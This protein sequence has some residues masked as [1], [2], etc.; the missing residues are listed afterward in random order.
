MTASLV[1]A[2]I[3]PKRIKVTEKYQYTVEPLKSPVARPIPSA[4]GKPSGEWEVIIPYDGGSNFTEAHWRAIQRQWS[5]P[6]WYAL[7]QGLRGFVNF[8][9]RRRT[10]AATDSVLER[11]VRIG[12][13]AF[14]DYHRTDLRTRLQLGIEHDTIQLDLPVQ[15]ADLPPRAI[16]R[17]QHHC[18]IHDSYEPAYPD[19]SPVQLKLKVQDEHELPASLEAL[20]QR[21]APTTEPGQVFQLRLELSEAQMFHQPNHFIPGLHVWLHLTVNFPEAPPEPPQLTQLAL[22]WPK[23]LAKQRVQLAYMSN[24]G[25]IRIAQEQPVAYDPEIGPEIGPESVKSMKGA[26]SWGN[27][28]LTELRKDEGAQSAAADPQV[29]YQ[30]PEM[31]LEIQ[32]GGELYGQA[33]LYGLARFKL[34]VPLSGVKLGLFDAAG[35]A[36]DFAPVYE[37]YLTLNF[38]IDTAHC[39]EAKQY[40]P[41]QTWYFEQVQLDLERVADVKTA[42]QDLGFTVRFAQV[43]QE[44]SRQVQYIVLARQPAGADTLWFAILMEGQQRLARRER[45]IPGGQ[46]FAS[47][48]P[49]GQLIL[50]VR[51]QVTG[52]HPVLLGRLNE[53]QERLKYLFQQTTIF[54]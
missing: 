9:G 44:E 43:A 17:N 6:W 12:Y 20:W 3:R 27:I 18:R 1:F 7:W 42:L 11:T 41:Q 32:P 39:L 50:R 10:N 13:L 23:T 35:Q 30:T 45:M 25:G 16:F 46:T 47:E 52:E 31:R 8:V 40:T 29:S 15:H 34:P 5:R 26:I 48:M 19:Q 14:G 33:E 2:N 36:S 28:P 22:C 37:S 51:G 38:T 4:A 53:L 24:E 54:H 49:T 21:L